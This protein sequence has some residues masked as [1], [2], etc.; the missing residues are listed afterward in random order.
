ML[1]LYGGYVR[2]RGGEIGI[3][4]LIKLLANFGLSEQSIRSAV[5]RMCHIGLLK[6]R[7]DGSKSYYSLTREGTNLLSKGAQRIYARKQEKWDGFWSTV[8]YYIPEEKRQARDQLRQELNWIGYGPLTTATWISPNDASQEVEE[9][10]MKLKVKEYIQIFQA[11]HK[12]C[13]DD[14]S[15][16]RRGWDLK[17]I[18]KRYMDF[19]EQFQPR[20]EELS[21]RVKKGQYVEPSECFVQ[22]FN[23]IEAYRRL[24]YFDPDLPEEL[25][26]G[27]W[28]RS[29]ARSVFDQYHDLLTEKANSYFDSV[30]KA[31]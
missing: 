10:A 31:Y 18:H 23:L 4:S 1:T 20:L 26:P 12:G 28:L 29:K 6:A 17:R 19:V 7:K 24:P 13:S 15:L 27:D 21:E 2:E 14:K 9:L 30:L 22:R 8:V 5:S 3:G 25:L 16:I 11:K